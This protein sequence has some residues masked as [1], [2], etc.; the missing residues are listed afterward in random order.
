MAMMTKEEKE[1]TKGWKIPEFLV[2]KGHTQEEF[3]VAPFNTRVI[4]KKQEARRL[5]DKEAEA[6]YRRM[7]K[8]S[9]ESLDYLKR[10]HGV[11]YVKEH[12]NVENAVREYGTAW[13]EE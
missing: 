4:L 5:G 1:L 12:Y 8:S 6:R 2:A 10:C 3:D 11:A 9:V 7:I 13:L